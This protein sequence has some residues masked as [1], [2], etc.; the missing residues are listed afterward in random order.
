MAVPDYLARY[1]FR[2]APTNARIVSL[3][4]EIVTVQHKG[5]RTGR[6]RTCALSGYKFMRRFLQHVLP[7][8]FHKVRYFGLWQSAHRHN[9]AR[10]PR[11][12]AI[13]RRAPPPDL[14]VRS[15]EPRVEVMSPNEPLI[16]HHCQGRLIF[17]RSLS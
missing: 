1:A 2:V 10:V 11:D 4:D 8:G 12:V 9:P 14:V 5:R 7:R 16:C 17:I 3:D 13:S 15:V 6:S